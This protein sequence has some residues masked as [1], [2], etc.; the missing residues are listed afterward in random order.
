MKKNSEETDF[1]REEEKIYQPYRP[2]RTV[3]W[4]R[5]SKH[6][7]AANLSEIFKSTPDGSALPLISNEPGQE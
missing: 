6:P 4:I 3:T 1:I 2:K 5:P 7:K